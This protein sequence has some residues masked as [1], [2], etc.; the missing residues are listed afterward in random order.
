MNKTLEQN[1]TC[2]DNN[3]FKDIVE[4]AAYKEAMSLRKLI[5]YE[6]ILR[7]SAGQ[8]T[9][10][11]AEAQEFAACLDRDFEALDYDEMYGRFSILAEI[12]ITY[13]RAGRRGFGTRRT[14]SYVVTDRYRTAIQW[15]DARGYDLKTL[16]A[17]P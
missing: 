3:G 15:L 11:A 10:P 17:R 14:M 9:I 4:S 16:T 5:G 8:I 2:P 7:L 13:R 6:N 1:G 12:C